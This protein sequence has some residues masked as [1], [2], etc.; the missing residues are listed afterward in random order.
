MLKLVVVGSTKCM[1]CKV[2]N[3]QI[4]KRIQEFHEL[5][6]DYLYVN[7]DGLEDKDTFIAKHKLMSTPTIWV[8]KDGNKVFEH[9]GYTDLDSLIENIGGLK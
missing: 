5:D 3:G 1:P 7:L 2:L 9:N 4:A 6:C 8:E